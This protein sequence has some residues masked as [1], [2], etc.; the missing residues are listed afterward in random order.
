MV[1]I[2]QRARFVPAHNVKQYS[3]SNVQ[4]MDGIVTYVNKRHGWYM[5]EA[6][7][8]YGR[9]RECFKMSRKYVE[10]KA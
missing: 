7:T 1:R 9:I 3:N 10:G 2:G 5:V 4:Y 6:F 8:P